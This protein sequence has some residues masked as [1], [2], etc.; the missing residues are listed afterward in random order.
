MFGEILQCCRT[1]S[2]ALDRRH[3]F[4]LAR[5]EGMGDCKILPGVTHKCT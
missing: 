4:D 1:S 2:R 5:L 3:G